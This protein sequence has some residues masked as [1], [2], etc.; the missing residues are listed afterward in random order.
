MR[1]LQIRFKNLNSLAGEWQIDLTHPAYS[2][3]GIFAI[4]G[5]T[6]AGKTTILDAICL[7]LYGST[8][9]LDK[10]SKGTNEIMSRHTGDCF[11]EV[12]FETQIG[13]FRCHWSQQKAKKKSNG[14]LQQPKQ[15]IINAL[16]DAVLETKIKQ[17]S[18]KIESVSGMDFDRFTRSMLLAQG[19][20]AAFLQAAPDH[21]APILEQ[22]TGTQIYSDISMRVHQ[23]QRDEQTRL[24]HL[25][26]DLSGVQVLDAEQI[27]Q[28]QSIL[29]EKTK[30]EKSL[31]EQST[32]THSAI[33]WLKTIDQLNNEINSLADEVKCLSEQMD[34]FQPNRLRL[35]WAC[36]AAAVDSSYAT[37][38]EFRRQQSDDQASLKR[39]EDALPA[40]QSS[41]DS[42][43]ELLKSAQKQ[44]TQAKLELK[45]SAPLIQQVRLLD[46]Q[47]ADREK[48]IVEA[49]KRCNLD[50]E[51]TAND[52]RSKQKA[53]TQ[54]TEIDR[55][56]GLVEAYFKSHTCDEW[57]ISGLASIEVQLGNLIARQKD[58]ALTSSNR[59]RA[60]S[61]LKASAQALEKCNKLHQDQR[62]KLK[63]ASKDLQR[64]KVALEQ[65]L[66]GRLLREHRSELESLFRE[67]AYLAR[68]AELE[69]HRAALEDGKPC[70]LCGADRHPYAEGNVPQPDATDQK[71]KELADRIEQSQKQED[72][73]KQLESDENQVKVLLAQCE[74]RESNAAKDK[75]AA[76][77]A[78]SELSSSL[79]TAQGRFD[80]LTRSILAQLRPLG[81]DEI[82]DDDSSALLDAL[83]QR[84]NAWQSH[85][86]MREDFTKR[87]TEYTSE[88]RRLD[89][90]I[91]T[92]AGNLK[93][94]RQQLESDLA[95]LESARQNRKQ[96]YGDRNPDA[97]EL[98]L[99]AAMDD[100]E[101]SEKK[102]HL[103]HEE[104]LQDL[105]IAQAQIASLQKRRTQ[106]EPERKKKE[107]AFNAGLEQS[108]FADEQH[109]LQSRLSADE[110]ETLSERAKQLDKN[111]ID[112]NARKI[113][114]TDR[115]NTEKEKQVTQGTLEELLSH[116]SRTEECLAQLRETLAALKQRLAENES[117][118]ES[119]RLKQEAVEAQRSECRRWSNLHELIG[120]ADG[121]KYRN[122]AQGLTFEQ[123]VSYANRQLGKMTDR[124]L[125]MRDAARPL[126]LNVIDNYQ[127]GTIRTTKNLSGGESFI[128]SLSLALGLSH[129][130]SKNVRVDSLFLDEGFGTLDDEALDM[131]LETLAS[132][133]HDGKLIGVISHVSALKER[134]STQIHVSPISGGRSQITGPGC[135]RID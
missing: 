36:K 61:T 47:L 11:A 8:P 132:L 105:K 54:L 124:Y 79:G 2:A 21:R 30:E 135:Q 22:I 17:V 93:L 6:G 59:D 56:L 4:T 69:D 24:N 112:L 114:R 119:I 87:K 134:I 27:E 15:E 88:I 125:L 58:L 77:N 46:Q 100:A 72:K 107:A 13:R 109:F 117:A 40:K 67:K 41:V 126:E 3:D 123:M 113:D 37:L 128:V 96:L 52:E 97:E 66:G 51:A 62:R 129:M 73:I 84:L 45:S 53:T 31:V 12:T 94:A 82:P 65:L 20:F 28:I 90:V 78:L 99:K 16:T 83:K 130:A 33:E 71:I 7:A 102:V 68:I 111:L 14:E 80:V 101:A 74:E 106:A 81:V 127:A 86:G 48:A 35:Q 9:R 115:L 57:L 29:T 55:D 60:D 120:S 110:R 1:I 133:Q 131:A 103:V 122:F 104:R 118:Q 64:A 34:L 76:E 23:R 19:G 43:F 5:P 38:S 32:Q 39:E 75:A 95:A 108:G 42:Q 70:P 121:K 49:Q 98:R 116:R 10:V 63:I 26:S 25:E 50:A 91:E 44:T 89:A 85:V 18:A 92:R